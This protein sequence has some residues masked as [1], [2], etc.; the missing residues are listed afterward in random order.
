MVWEM[1]GNDEFCY[2]VIE[3][4]SLNNAVSLKIKKRRQAEYRFCQCFPHAV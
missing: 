1:P 3:F 2:R 4:G